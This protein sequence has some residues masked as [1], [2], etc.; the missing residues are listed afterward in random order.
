M[1]IEEKLL[2]TFPAPALP[3]D[4]QVVGVILGTRGVEQNVPPP[5]FINS[6]ER[7]SLCKWY[8]EVAPF[9]S[10]GEKLFVPLAV[11]GLILCVQRLSGRKRHA[12]AKGT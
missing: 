3:S 12:K 2:P 11:T 4:A 1:E 9:W 8:R 10:L 6:Y 5:F 7:Q